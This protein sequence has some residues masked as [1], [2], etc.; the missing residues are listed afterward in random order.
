MEK[1]TDRSPLAQQDD[2]PI[3][4]EARIVLRQ[5]ILAAQSGRVGKATHNPSEA[6]MEKPKPQRHVSIF[7]SEEGPAPKRRS[8]GTILTGTELA[9]FY[10]ERGGRRIVSDTG[11]DSPGMNEGD[12]ESLDVMF[13]QRPR[14]DALLSDSD[15]HRGVGDD[16]DAPLPVPHTAKEDVVPDELVDSDDLADSE[17]PSDIRP[18]RQAKT[19]QRSGEIIDP[20]LPDSAAIWLRIKES[21]QRAGLPEIGAAWGI[22]KSANW[23]HYHKTHPFS[24]A[25]RK[26]LVAFL[27]PYLNGKQWTGMLE[28]E[29]PQ[30]QHSQRIARDY[31]VAR[32]KAGLPP[33][34]QAAVDIALLPLEEKPEAVK[35]TIAPTLKILRTMGG[36]VQSDFGGQSKDHTLLNLEQN[37]FR[38][39]WV[40]EDGQIA[41]HER[42]KLDAVADTLA[43]GLLSPKAPRRRTDIE[44]RSVP[45]RLPPTARLPKVPAVPVVDTSA[46]DAVRYILDHATLNPVPKEQMSNHTLAVDYLAEEMRRQFKDMPMNANL[47]AA[48]NRDLTTI[49]EGLRVVPEGRGRTLGA[50]LTALQGALPDLHFNRLPGLK[51]NFLALKTNGSTNIMEFD[52]G[53]RKGAPPVLNQ[54]TRGRLSAF[55]GVLTKRWSERM[56][57]TAVATMQFSAAPSVASTMESIEL[58]M[59]AGIGEVS[60][61]ASSVD[62]SH[63]DVGNQED[64]GSIMSLVQDGPDEARVT[65]NSANEAGYVPATI[66]DTKSAQHIPAAL[67]ELEELARR[68][69]VEKAVPGEGANSGHATKY[70]GEPGMNGMMQATR[71]C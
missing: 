28:I 41:E 70:L 8:V 25:D 38:V 63:T 43:Q 62:V 15:D 50:T 14:H 29:E 54:Q 64:R 3:N 35:N 39:E 47:R 49:L 5:A 69:A 7:A 23:V 10:R 6:A 16:I 31:L 17:T 4:A 68:M 37:F 2:T 65:A 18:L 58:P 71:R 30:W 42:I 53:A 44:E 48:V 51:D 45:G 1:K 61:V 46:A 57:T 9:K 19:T 26:A 21:K 22:E 20:N 13:T 52:R 33:E 24:P 67:K 36:L 11:S 56:R 60:S 12:I 40:N 34:K 32:V 55:A 66:V 59:E 27:D